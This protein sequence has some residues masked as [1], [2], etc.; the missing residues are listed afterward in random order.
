LNFPV[1]NDSFNYPPPNGKFIPLIQKTKTLYITW[2]GYYQS[3]PKTHK[4]SLGQKIDNFFIEA[5]EAMAIASF[6]PPNAK[7]PHVCL[8]IQK[9]DL[10][11]IMLMVLWEVKAIDNNKYLN[12]SQP[13]DEIGRMLGGWYG[14]LI[15]Q[16]SPAKIGEKNKDSCGAQPDYRR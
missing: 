14:K 6:L 7:P 3:L 15:K 2:H 4:Y 1:H 10:L 11:K 9:N 5:L 16:N 8:A 12:L 13:L